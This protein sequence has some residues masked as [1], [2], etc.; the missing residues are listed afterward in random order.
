MSPA[1]RNLAL[2]HARGEFVTWFD[3]DDWQ[4][5][6]KVERLVRA[7]RSGKPFAGSAESWFLDLHTLRCTRYLAPGRRILFNGAGF[8]TDAARKVAFPTHVK[9]ASDTRWMEAM[10]RRFGTAGE[11]LDQ[12]LF[13]WLCHDGNLSNPA[14]KRRFNRDFAAL[15][16][17]ID[18]A[19]PGGIPA[20]RWR[21]SRT[22]WG[23]R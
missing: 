4:H 15:E 17:H 6:E 21:H 13:F 16:A 23:A 3:D 10:Q 18:G 5:P 2:E 12:P 22:D 11:V 8:R 1:K 14:T 9:K 19:L 20:V 7:L